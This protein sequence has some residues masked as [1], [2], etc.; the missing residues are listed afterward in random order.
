MVARDALFASLKWE[1]L[2]EEQ[3]G[4]FSSNFSVI[5]VQN[6]NMVIQFYA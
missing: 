3:G 4:L 6:P 5:Y 1:M 2:S